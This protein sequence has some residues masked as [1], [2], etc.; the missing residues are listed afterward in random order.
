MNEAAVN[1]VL[2]GSYEEVMHNPVT[3]IRGKDFADNRFVSDKT[4]G[5][6]ALVG[7]VLQFCQKIKEKCFPIIFKPERVDRPGFVFPAFV[8]GAKQVA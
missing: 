5:L 2:D 7:S 1:G 3:E 4:D 6:S 8:V